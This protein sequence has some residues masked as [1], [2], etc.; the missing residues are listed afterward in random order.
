VRYPES[1][2]DLPSRTPPDT[3]GENKATHMVPHT[4]GKVPNMAYRMYDDYSVVD[5]P[6]DISGCMSDRRNKEGRTSAGILAT[7]GKGG[8]DGR[9]GPRDESRLAFSLS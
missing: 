2:F 7:A 9:R 3:S 6:V 8:L 4:E 1:F 5:T